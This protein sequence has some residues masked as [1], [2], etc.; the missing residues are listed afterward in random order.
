MTVAFD[1]MAAGFVESP[2]AHYAALRASDPVHHSDLL[3]GWVLT[4]YADVDRVLRDPS[5]S[6][7]AVN[8]PDNPVLAAEVG[9]MQRDNRSA[10]TLVLLDDP[11]HA[12]LRRLLQAPFG[13]R[14]IDG[15]R[16][17]V[18]ARVG[19]AMDELAG[20]GEMDVVADFAY[21]LPVGIFCELLGVPPEDSPKFRHWTKA[22]ARNLDPLVSIEEREANLVLHDEMTGYLVDLVEVKRQHPGD[23]IMSALVQAEEDGDRLSR[24]ELV[25]QVLTLYV[26]GHEPV[27]ALVAN[28]L[29]ALL[30]QPAELARL[31]GDLSLLHHAVLELLRFDGPNQFVRRIATAP[32]DFEVG[33]EVR[34]IPAGDVLYCCIGAA[35]HDPAQFGADADVVRVDRPEAATHLQ[36]GSGIHTCLG[37]HLA[38]LQAEA[39]LGQLLGRLT[40]LTLAGDVTW[41]PR[42][43][44]RAVD[45][46]P[47]TYRARG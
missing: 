46:L 28:G 1:P 8:A 15:I 24:D 33:G 44:L 32:L 36:F 13:P 30:A 19:E 37:T 41:S 26:A 18:Q 10:A 38:R 7:E 39:M 43:V 4:R 25:M 11:D 42:M 40:N 29:V 2:Y 31:Q 9:R 20:R 14:A 5:V 12:R 3:S 22:V 45:S 23:D 35:N 16:T 21:P 17:V 27:S 47:I 6:V 34:T